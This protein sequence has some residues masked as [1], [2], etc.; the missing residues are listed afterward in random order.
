MMGGRSLARLADARRVG[1]RRDDDDVGR[2][3]STAARERVQ[4][5]RRIAHQCSTP[6]LYRSTLATGRGMNVSDFNFELPDELIAQDA[7]PRGTSR[8]LVLDRATGDV[9]PHD[10]R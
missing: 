8:L 5:R 1:I 7:A 3:A 4:V 9:P 2:L 10:H 6:R